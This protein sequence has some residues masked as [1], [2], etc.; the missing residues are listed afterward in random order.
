MIRVAKNT[1]A[2]SSLS[3]TK[4]YD[5]EDVKQTL[6]IDHFEKCYICERHLVTD[7]QVEHLNSK[8]PRQDWSNLF[9]SCGYCNQKKSNRHDGII[10]PVNNNVEEM[11]SQEIDYSNK[12]AV[13]SSHS[14]SAQI[15]PTI[16]LLSKVFNGKNGM[17]EKKEER[18]F[19]YCMSAVI[20]FQTL[21]SSYLL[22]KDI[23]VRNAIEEELSIK[24]ELLG[25]KYW[26]IQSNPVLIAEF[27]PL[28]VWNKQ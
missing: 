13:F 28:I 25:F 23:I 1:V 21:V 14:A 11:I 19:E 3:T 2:P 22:T 17:R 9:L 10:D 7:Y 5:G 15:S 18:F 8:A 12:K 6:L 26:I 20:H 16:E 27:E 24:R 4:A